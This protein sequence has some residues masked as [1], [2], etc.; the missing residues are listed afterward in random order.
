MDKNEI[1]S[2]KM[3]LNFLI[4]VGG[5]FMLLLFAFLAHFVEGHLDRK[6]CRGKKAAPFLGPHFKR[7]KLGWRF[8]DR[9]CKLPFRRTDG[10]FGKW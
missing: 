7:S 1:D 5:V 6:N 10:N 4:R 2:P 9:R 3:T 8:Q